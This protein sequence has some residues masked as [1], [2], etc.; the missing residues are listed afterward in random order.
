M[1]ILSNNCLLKKVVCLV[2]VSLF[3]FSICCKCK[4][5][6]YRSEQ[7]TVTNNTIPSNGIY[8]YD[9]DGNFTPSKMWKVE[10]NSKVVGIAIITNRTKALIALKNA[11]DGKKVIWGPDGFV[12]GI[13]RSEIN[14]NFKPGFAALDYNGEENTYLLLNSLLPN[15]GTAIRIAKDFMFPDGT[16]GYLP[17]LGELIDVFNN[18]NEVNELLM[19]V[20]GEIIENTW[21]WTSTQH[22][23]N[24][25][26]WAYGGDASGSNS[27]AQLRNGNSQIAKTYGAAYLLVRPFGTINISNHIVASKQLVPNNVEK[28]TVEKPAISFV[29]RDI[30]VNNTIDK[31]TF[32][33]IIG[34]EHYKNETNV[35][36]A[37]NDAKILKEYVQKTLGVPEKQIKF[38]QD[39][40]LNDLRIA[41]RWLK[42]A[43]EVCNGQGKAIFYYAGHGIPDEADKTAYLL[44]TD[45]IGSDTESAYSLQRLYDELGN[46]P[47][48][49]TI[50]FLDACFSGSKREGG[51]MMSARGVAIKVKS[52][53]PQG[54]LIIFTAAQGEE[55]A[56]PYKEQQHGMFT[57]FLLKKL[58][59]TK[60]EAT[61]GEIAD[62]LITEVK[63]ESFIENNK[64]QTPT[65]NVAPVLENSWRNMKVKE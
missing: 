32:V 53:T 62:Y 29:D 36:F 4:T 22:Y 27:F 28:A 60:G 45:G 64:M 3:T 61:L 63:R 34:N 24:Y 10:N 23:L 39:A 9:T 7:I 59:E 46:M 30:I 42:Q 25:R 6:A 52:M 1:N 49:R 50:V 40:G 21:Y 5:S 44:P 55:T 18:L 26:A 43:M 58:Q 56:Y 54:N 16:K 19:K 2:L 57:Y 38:V 48:Q 14:S 8:V 15:A 11:H 41:V 37:E 20:G 51:M 47:A 13:S 12:N 65:V 17:A 33:V 35:P 31:N